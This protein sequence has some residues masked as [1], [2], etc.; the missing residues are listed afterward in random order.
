MAFK[1]IE[2]RLTEPI[3]DCQVRALWGLNVS[4]ATVS[5]FLRCPKCKTELSVPHERFVACISYDNVPAPA[6][7][8]TKKTKLDVLE[9]GKVINLSES[10]ET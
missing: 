3:C 9:G 6:G 2:I 1:N 4:L 10:K 8:P 5:L 7:T